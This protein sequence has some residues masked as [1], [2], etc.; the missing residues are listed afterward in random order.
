VFKAEVYDFFRLFMLISRKKMLNY[1][2]LK[3]SYLF[4]SMSGKPA[5]KGK[6][7]FI[8]VEPTTL[9]NLRCPECF[10]TKPGFTRPKGNLT[11]ETFE[12]IISQSAEYAFYLNLYFQGEPFLNFGLLDF[13]TYAKQSGFYV[14][15][16][17]NG[18]FIDETIAE[19]LI[20]SGLDRLI[21]SLDGTDAETYSKYRKGG[22][23][24]TV[25]NGVRTLVELRK[26]MKSKIPFLEIQFVLT[27][28]NQHQQKDIKDLGKK[29]GADK[30]SIKSFQLLNYDKAGEWVPD[31]NSRYT[32]SDD[33]SVKAKNKLLNRCFRMWSSCVVTWD[34]NVIPCCFDKNAS[35]MM[36]NINQQNLSEIWNNDVY[37]NF[38]KK[39]FSERKNIDICCNC[40]E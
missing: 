21:I 26:K 7:A 3:S 22:D 9:C 6:P 8:S 1:F 37:N 25:V 5:H 31:I 17:T 12:K 14:S 28:K 16:S 38:R 34:G 35:C 36:G 15:V 30:V 18:H 4:S 11:K 10:T 29:L 23:F 33:G 27:R 24:D 32:F 40:S 2:K 19:K 20:H 13:I 39:V